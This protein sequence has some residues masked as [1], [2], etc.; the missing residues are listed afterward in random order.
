MNQNIVDTALQGAKHAPLMAASPTTTNSLH[1]MNT[2][3]I[4]S[5][6]NSNITSSG[7]VPANSVNKNTRSNNENVSYVNGHNSNAAGG[8][9]ELVQSDLRDKQRMIDRLMN[10]NQDRNEVRFVNYQL[11]LL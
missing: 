5:S 11:A 2:Q 4:A 9:M 3:P 1:S 7:S 6:C 10:E 8:Y